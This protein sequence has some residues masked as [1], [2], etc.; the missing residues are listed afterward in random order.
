MF[1]VCQ[2]RGE[3]VRERGERRRGKRAGKKDSE[4]TNKLNRNCSGV[5]AEWLGLKEWMERLPVRHPWQ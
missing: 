4:Y 3:R 5:L 1:L 2:E